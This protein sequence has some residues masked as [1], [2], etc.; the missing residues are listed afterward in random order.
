[1]SSDFDYAQLKWLQWGGP[2]SNQAC[3][4]HN[5]LLPLRYMQ[6]EK[7]HLTILYVISTVLGRS[8]FFNESIPCQILPSLIQLLKAEWCIYVSVVCV[9]PSNLASSRTYK[10]AWIFC[11]T[12]ITLLFCHILASIGPKTQVWLHVL[13]ATCLSEWKWLDQSTTCHS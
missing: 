11:G 5:R 7:R 13:S 3:W 8:Y 10:Q 6:R 9:L 4:A 1:M 12:G 2:V